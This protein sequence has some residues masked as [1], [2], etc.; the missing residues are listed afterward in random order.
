MSALT[1]DSGQHRH[2]E[3][4]LGRAGAE[5]WITEAAECGPGLV[6]AVDQVDSL[7]GLAIG[8]APTGRA[9]R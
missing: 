7:W 9:S 5:Q 1:R 3:P 2:Q 4:A 6:D 8:S